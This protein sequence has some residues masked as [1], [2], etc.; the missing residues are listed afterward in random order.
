MEHEPLTQ[1]GWQAWDLVV[2]C[3]GQLRT[4]GM[5]GVSGLD[6]PAA[7]EMAR[8]RGYDQSMMAQ[9]LPGCEAGIVSGYGMR[10]DDDPDPGEY[11]GR[12]QG[13]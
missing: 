8:L 5:G 1:E 12:E 13:E 9:L 3:Q 6:L 7:L 11:A 10:D 4:A 2:V